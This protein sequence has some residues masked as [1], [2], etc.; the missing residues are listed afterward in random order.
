[1]RLN[2]FE[3]SE[4]KIASQIDPDERSEIGIP[5]KLPLEHLYTTSQ[6]L[7]SFFVDTA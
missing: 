2:F 6:T 4:E 7:P 1:M 3:S 5:I